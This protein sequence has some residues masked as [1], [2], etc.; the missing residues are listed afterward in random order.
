[1]DQQVEKELRMY[2]QPT[3]L[4]AW[5]WAN[6]ARRG[7]LPGG[8]EK[9]RPLLQPPSASLLSVSLR[10]PV[11]SLQTEGLLS[12]PHTVPFSLAALPSSNRFSLGAFL[13]FFFFLF[14]VE[15]ICSNQP[16][17]PCSLD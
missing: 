8:G 13:I 10:E 17:L 4:R 16:L 3:S 1:M 15:H 12:L 14:H 6:G 2:F 9:R 7:A 5:G 11:M